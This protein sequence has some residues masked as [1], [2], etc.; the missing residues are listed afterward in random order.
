MQGMQVE[1]AGAR[2]RGRANGR[3][4]VCSLI[5]WERDRHRRVRP[6]IMRRMRRLALAC[7]CVAVVLVVPSAQEGAR[8]PQIESIRADEMRAD[9]FFLASDGMRGR[10]TDTPENALA[11]DWVRSRFERLGL[12]P[13]GH[14][15][16]YDHHYALMTATL[17]E[18]NA[19]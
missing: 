4:R 18:G 14:R 5:P 7:C 3:A 2:R 17:G 13:A 19:M 6:S 1:E 9:L 8:A 15:G 12:R 10:L 16:T 11:A